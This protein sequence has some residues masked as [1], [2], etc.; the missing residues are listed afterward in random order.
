MESIRITALR[1]NQE[2]PQQI[3]KFLAISENEI[4][5][6]NFFLKDRNQGVKHIVNTSAKEIHITVQRHSYRT[7]ARHNNLC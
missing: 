6:E 7:K 4:D 3:K 5:L 1:R 2:V